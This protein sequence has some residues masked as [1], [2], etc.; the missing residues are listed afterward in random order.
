MIDETI[1]AIATSAGNAGV[2]IVRLSGERAIDIADKIFFALNKKSLTS[3]SEREIFF[4]HVKNFSG[5][6]VDEAIALVMREPKSYTRENVVELQCHGGSVVLREVLKLT[7]EAGA[8]PAQRGEFTKRAFLNGRI[9]LTQ[10]QAV[11]DVIQAKTSVALTVAQNQL[12]GRTSQTIREIRQA[13]LN[14]VAHIEAIIDFPE[15]DLDDVTIAEVDKNISAQVENLDAL[16][17]NQSA[18]KILRE[19][20]ETA[21]IGKPNV[22]KS[23]LLNFFAKT[24]RAIVTEIPGTTRDQIEEFVNVDGIPL[25]IVDTAGIRNSSDAVEKIGIERAKTCAQRAELILA[26]FDSSRP[27]DD[28]DAEIFKLLPDRNAMVLLTKTDLPEVTTVE[29]LAKKIPAAQVIKISLHSGS[30]V[31]EML[32]TISERVG[33]IDFEMSFV[34]DEREADLLR[35]AVNHLREAQK[36]IRLNIGLDF[37]SI[38]LRA[39]LECLSELTGESV[40]EDVL[41]EIFSKFCVGK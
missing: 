1:S 5:K 34:R 8:R 11:L 17:K 24:E 32:K 6:I 4:G 12:A 41:N 38:D 2:G 19:G 23:S 36:T 33:K 28:E 3:A 13:I 15:D 30:G 16:L 9:D 21:I 22:G 25:K 31:D 40:T 29:V 26:L 27:L 20:L 37:V 7:F 14:S 39:A 35:R 10:A 18:G